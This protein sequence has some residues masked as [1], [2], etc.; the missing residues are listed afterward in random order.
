MS[1]TLYEYPG[2]LPD[3]LTLYVGDMLAVGSAAPAAETPD[4]VRVTF[5]FGDAS[6][7]VLLN[8]EVLANLLTTPC[9]VAP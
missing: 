4:D 2:D 3:P 6:G 7:S 5:T 9:K 8:D 1:E